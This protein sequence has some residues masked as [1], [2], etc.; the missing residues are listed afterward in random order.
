MTTN[1]INYK[2]WIRSSNNSNIK[3]TFNNQ[4][5]KPIDYQTSYSYSYTEPGTYTK[6]VKFLS[7]DD[8]CIKECCD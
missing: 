6:E 2:H 1:N 8:L 3:N 7:N 5:K 4:I